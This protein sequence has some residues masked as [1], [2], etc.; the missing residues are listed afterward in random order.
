M[1]LV[2]LIFYVALA[3]SGH[4]M[5]VRRRAARASPRTHV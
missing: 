1:V 4:S 2:P 5:Q 3:L